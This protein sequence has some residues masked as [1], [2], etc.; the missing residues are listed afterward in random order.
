MFTGFS[1]E[2]PGATVTKYRITRFYRFYLV[3]LFP[4]LFCFSFCFDSHFDVFERADAAGS[5]QPM[6]QNRK[7]CRGV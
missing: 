1:Q 4:S 5:R 3:T 2:R 7:S 6:Q